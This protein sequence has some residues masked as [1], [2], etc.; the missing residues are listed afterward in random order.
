KRYTSVGADLTGL[1][2]TFPWLEQRKDDGTIWRNHRDPAAL[3]LYWRV[4]HKPETQL[5]NIK[6]EAF[7]LIADVHHDAVDT[8]V[9]LRL[10]PR[11][12]IAPQP[13]IMD[14]EW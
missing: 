2:R 7:I 13:F 1:F 4:P 6:L 3:R 9:R 12:P 5:F 14:R 8:Q 11:E 10:V